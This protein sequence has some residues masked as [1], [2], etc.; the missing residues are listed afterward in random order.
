M[1]VTKTNP[2]PLTPGRVDEIEA[3]MQTTREFADTLDP[4]IEKGHLGW[5]L[6]DAEAL[7]YSHRAL[8]ARVAEVEAALETIAYDDSLTE[9]E[10][11]RIASDALAQPGSESQG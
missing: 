7:I 3:N 11:H 4:S 9:G 10:I 2:Q 1:T 8:S 6:V 5:M